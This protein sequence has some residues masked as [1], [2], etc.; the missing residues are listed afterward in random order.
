MKARK[1]FTI[2]A[3]VLL[4]VAAAEAARL[5]SAF[6]NFSTKDLDG[7]TVTN[8]IFGQSEITMINF[9]A[10]WCGPCVAEMPDLAKMYNELG[11]GMV[12]VLMDAD[13][14]GAIDKANQILKK[15]GANFPQ[16]RPSKEMYSLFNAIDAIPTTIFVD[17]NGK[18]VG[19]TVVGS[20]SSREYLQAMMTAWKDAYE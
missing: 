6:P 13:D 3:A 17:S 19:Q 9:W 7:K 18:I 4:I 12:G 16:L 1:I 14:R 11:E 15:A 8:S 5:P 10:T 20:R 2:L